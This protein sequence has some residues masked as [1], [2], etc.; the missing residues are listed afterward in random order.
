MRRI[1][2][3]VMSC[4]VAAVP[5]LSQQRAT[6]PQAAP[7]PALEAAQRAFDALPESERR[8]IQDDLIWA[9]DFTA[10][11]SGSYG[12]RT[13]DAILSFKRASKLRADA[14]L[15]DRE[16]K[17]LAETAARARAAAKFARIVD[18][19]TGAAY[20]LPRALLTK[21]E[22]QIGRASCRERV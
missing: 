6:A 19:R 21:S 7:D 10:T 20:G 4:F 9:A 11:V 17:L 3:V 14:L 8:A 2:P 22:Q 15:D 16:R 12:R 5:A 1:L 13:H 18:A